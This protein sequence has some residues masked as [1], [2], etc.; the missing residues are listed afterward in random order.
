MPKLLTKT[1]NIVIFI[2]LLTIFP[3]TFVEGFIAY[4]H[5]F[6]DDEG[7]KL[8]NQTYDIFYKICLN[9]AYISLIITY[10]AAHF[11]T[12]IK[13]IKLWIKLL[14][15]SLTYIIL[16]IIFIFTIIFISQQLA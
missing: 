8:L 5:H 11:I 13:N 14:L 15:I 7:L 16:F 1:K 10:I 4:L 3:L 6:S 9:S 12:K 2:L